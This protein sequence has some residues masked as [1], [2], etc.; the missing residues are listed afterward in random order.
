MIIEK[1]KKW[2]VSLPVASTFGASAQCKII[3]VLSL[4][5]K[6][7]AKMHIAGT[8]GHTCI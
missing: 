2:T 8:V 1:K 4:I 5:T 7:G 3:S 6:S